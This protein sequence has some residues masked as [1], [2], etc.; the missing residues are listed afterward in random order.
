MSR[1]G[2]TWLRHF[3]FADRILFVAVPWVTPIEAP[4]IQGLM[5]VIAALA[6]ETANL[7]GIRPS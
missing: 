1:G 5:R 6:C 3:G 2:A 7:F 4:V